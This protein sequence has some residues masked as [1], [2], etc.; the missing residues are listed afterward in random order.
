MKRG[1]TEA[2]RQHREDIQAGTEQMPEDPQ[3]YWNWMWPICTTRRADV[4][5]DLLT[6][7]ASSVPSELSFQWQGLCVQVS[8][9]FITN[10][11]SFVNCIHFIRQETR[12]L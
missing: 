7:L 10:I 1:A 12:Q 8:K 2:L 11:N 9:A 6:V 5:A 4:A 3:R